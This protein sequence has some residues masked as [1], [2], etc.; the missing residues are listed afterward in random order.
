MLPLRNSLEIRGWGEMNPLN[1]PAWSLTFEYIGNLLYA[2]FIRRFPNLLLLSRIGKSIRLRG[3]FWWCSALILILLA[4]PRI[5]GTEHMWMNGAYEALCILLI[6]PLIVMTG[7]GSTVTGR[8]SA[9][10]CSF[11]GAISYP[12]Y[13]THYPLVYMQIAW[14]QAH[15]D[16]PL[17]T[18]VCL[19]VSVFILS[20]GIAYA[21]LKL[22]D[23]PVREWLR[24]HW[25]MKKG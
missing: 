13:I 7:A 21:G 12:L 23:L 18:A 2:L 4:M 9:A 1:G 16:T 24:K 19:S 6:F 17:G 5:G 22:Y 11:L 3:G 14:A 10:V 20:V 25:L 8:R 15:P